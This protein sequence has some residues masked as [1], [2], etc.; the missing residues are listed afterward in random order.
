MTSR[1]FAR[2]CCAAYSCNF[3]AAHKYLAVFFLAGNLRNAGGPTEDPRVVKNRHPEALSPAVESDHRADQRHAGWLPVPTMCFAISM[4]FWGSL[5]ETR[6]SLPGGRCQNSTRIVATLAV[7]TDSGVRA[8]GGGDQV[9][10]AGPAGRVPQAFRGG[11]AVVSPRCAA[12]RAAR[13][14]VRGAGK[15]CAR[16]CRGAL[17]A[18]APCRV[19]GA[20]GRGC[21]AEGGRG[22]EGAR[23][24]RRGGV[25]Q[26]RSRALAG[27]L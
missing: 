4:S 3:G 17:Q 1:R 6:Q 24:C 26:G 27:E 19:R 22:R 8:T 16:G 5:A 7:R 10:A 2:K 21:A 12:G 15:C 14:F 18:G 20:R 13:D 25:A 23:T 11:Q 9:L